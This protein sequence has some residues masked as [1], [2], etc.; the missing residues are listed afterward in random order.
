MY[1]L[2]A[3]RSPISYEVK[4]SELMQWALFPQ[5]C[6]FERKFQK[7]FFITPYQ[8]Q[9]AEYVLLIKSCF[10]LKVILFRF[11]VASR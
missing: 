4:I 1:S 11:D 10:H 8:S 3:I 2:Y 5:E 7:V 9:R 6:I